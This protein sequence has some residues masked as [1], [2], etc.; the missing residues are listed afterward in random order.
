MPYEYRMKHR[1]E[2][3]DTDMAGIVHFANF[4]RFME[5]TEHSFLNEI[6]LSVYR[7]DGDRIISCPRVSATCDYKSPLRFGDEFEVHLLVREK[8]TRSLTYDFVFRKLD[9][10]STIARGS[11]SIVFVS[12]DER[13][14]M[15]AI[16]I[17]ESV[18]RLIEA[19]PSDLLRNSPE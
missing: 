17:P 1:V 11:I 15:K 8:R 4:F 10:D 18:E 9:S 2:F 5:A 16:P 12:I 3:V 13:G 7:Q 14:S 19:A 6:G